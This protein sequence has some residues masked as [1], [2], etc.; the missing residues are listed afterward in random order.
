MDKLL[1]LHSSLKN[2][3]QHLGDKSA[4]STENLGTQSETS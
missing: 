4:F 2:V 3:Q 1:L